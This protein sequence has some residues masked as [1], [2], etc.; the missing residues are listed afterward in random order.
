M[1]TKNIIF[2]VIY[3]TLIFLSVDVIARS[4]FEK[5]DWTTDPKLASSL[6][7]ELGIKLESDC[8]DIYSFDGASLVKVK[9]GE[10][11]LVKSYFI[12]DIDKAGF[13]LM[14]TTVIENNGQPDCLGF[15]DSEVGSELDLYFRLNEDKSEMYFYL[16][17][18]EPGALDAYLKKVN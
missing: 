8:I 18:S 13:F 2:S 4:I 11:R 5:G 17:P 7:S 12:R 9:S 15:K 6:A 3:L 1:N 10:Q 16:V 14:K